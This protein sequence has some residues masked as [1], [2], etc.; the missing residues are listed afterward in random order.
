MLS[1]IRSKKSLKDVLPKK[2]TERLPAKSRKEVSPVVIKPGR[3]RF[4]YLLLIVFILVGAV[5]VFSSLMAK[6]T[7][8][9]TPKQ[10]RLELSESFSATK[11][12]AGANSVAYEVV[13]L[14][15]T[16]ANRLVE[17]S[18]SEQVA[19]QA[20]GQAL[21]SNNFN[22]TSQ[23]L[24]ANTRLES[25]SGKIYRLAAGVTVPGK[26]AN[27]EPGTVTVEIVADAA[28]EAY[29]SK[30]KLNFT[31]PGFKG[32]PRY[33]GFF[34]K[35]TGEISGGFAGT[36]QVVPVETKRSVT[37]ELKAELRDHL[38]TSARGQI[39]P[40]FV[41]FD[42]SVFINFTDETDWSVGEAGTETKVDIALSGEL[43][44]IIFNRRDLSKY[45]IDDNLPELESLN[46]LIA[47][48]DELTFILNHKDQVDLSSNNDISFGLSGAMTVVAE[49]DIAALIDQLAGVKKNEANLVLEGHKEIERAEVVF[50]PLW[51][52]RFP[53]DPADI[54]VLNSL[55][56]EP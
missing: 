4:G 19:R 54:T 39:P 15:A 30:E 41:L 47:N 24:V 44:G 46:L 52:R 40:E 43:Q 17:V 21:I 23:Q 14:P 50:R 33:Q 49:P 8:T 12:R 37:E 22:N 42:D 3:F 38:L 6:A 36:M 27:G 48:L 45:V 51:A 18:G 55:E 2:T 10:T 29:N 20:R 25:P 26:K 32:S 1:E 34:A 7:V 56:L 16:K 5:Y 11:S 28:G 13:T 35:S 9:L 31:I 53:A